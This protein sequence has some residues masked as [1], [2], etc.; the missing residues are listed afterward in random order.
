MDNL[1]KYQKYLSLKENNENWNNENIM[2]IKT[3]I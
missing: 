1:N 3:N 2:N